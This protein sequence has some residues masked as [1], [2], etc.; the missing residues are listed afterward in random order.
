MKCDKHKVTELRNFW[1]D[2][3]HYVTVCDECISERRE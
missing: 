3:G 1:S 2:D